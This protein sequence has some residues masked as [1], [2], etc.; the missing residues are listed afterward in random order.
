MRWLGGWT[1][2]RE[3]DKRYARYLRGLK[4]DS[5]EQRMQA[6]EGPGV[7]AACQVLGRAESR[8]SGMG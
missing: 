5:E 6:P 1:G 7:K 3:K 2:T 4:A 8:G